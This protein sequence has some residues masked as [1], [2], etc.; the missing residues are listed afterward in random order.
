MEYQWTAAAHVRVKPDARK[1]IRAPAASAAVCLEG[2]DR[3]TLLCG[4]TKGQFSLLDLIRAVIAITGPADVTLSTWTAG[5]RD[6]ETLAWLVEGQQIKSLRL[7][8]DRSFP[9]RQPK[10]CSRLLSL[11]GQEAILMTMTHAKFVIVKSEGWSVVIRT[12]MNLNKNRR[13]EQFDV[14]DDP[15]LAAFFLAFADEL[16]SNQSAGRFV[17]YADLDRSFQ[18]TLGEGAVVKESKARDLLRSAA[19]GDHRRVLRGD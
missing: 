5:I 18:K 11:F 19:V 13:F 1:L 14:D 4:L 16:A 12:S 7:I 17:T 6:V 9:S 3:G 2:F 15:D 10:Y 8:V